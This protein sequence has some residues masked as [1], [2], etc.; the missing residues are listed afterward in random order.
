[1]IRKIIQIDEQGR[2]I[3]LDDKGTGKTF[4]TKADCDAY[5]YTFKNGHCRI[6]QSKDVQKNDYNANYGVNNTTSG[7]NN[8]SLGYNN[9]LKGSGAVSIGANNITELNAINSVA[10]GSNAYA[11]QY[12]EFALSNSLTANRSKFSIIQYNGITTDDVDTELYIGGVHSQRFLINEDFESAFAID[13][14]ATALNAAS[15]E[16][17]TNYGH[18]TYKFVNSTLSEVGHSKST[19]I[20]DSNL[21]YDI[22][23]SAVSSTPDYIKV[24]ATGETAHT[25]YWSLTI[26]ITEVRYG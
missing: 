10:I 24:V 18:V 1:M 15:N 19:T 4:G 17:W 21:D 16:I 22:N 23:F 13:Y 8:I 6:P 9:N 3:F 2:I 14:T 7:V 20:R 25:V 11:E 26:K 12:G 5:G